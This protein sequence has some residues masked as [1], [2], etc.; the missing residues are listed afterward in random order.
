MDETDVQIICAMAFREGSYNLLLDRHPRPSGIAR[1]LSLDEKTIRSRVGRME[2]D[3]FIKYYQAVPS[4][5]LF[6]FETVGSFRFEAV[7]L[8]TKHAAVEALHQ[9]PRVLEAFDYLGTTVVV[10][11][12]GL[13]PEENREAAE[14]MARQFEMTYQDLGTSSLDPSPMAPD[15]LDWRIIQKLRY[16]A[17]CTTRDLARALSITPRMA[18]YRLARL[19]NSRAV[20]IRAIL[21]SQRQQGLVFY[22]LELSVDPGFETSVVE[23]LRRRHGARVWSVQ[24]PSAGPLIL[25]LFGFTLAEPE[26][27][28]LEALGLPGVR[29]SSVFVQK[30]AFEPRRPNWIDQRID[31]EIARLEATEPLAGPSRRSV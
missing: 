1:R 16:D 21:N 15:R 23:Q 13:S 29:R 12:V 10:S 4:L 27:T 28:A 26:A 3:G 11:F 30:E 18:E 24:P 6:G 17:R 14:G 25:N 8:A 20:R 22:E 2:K 19:L 7:N 9:L 31:R 5:A